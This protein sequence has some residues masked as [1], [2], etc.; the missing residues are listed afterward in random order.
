MKVKMLKQT[1]INKPLVIG[2]EVE[3]LSDLAVRLIK[4][5]I[6]EEMIPRND[7]GEPDYS[8]MSNKE[9][10]VLCKERGIVLDK[11]LYTSKSAEEK[12]E[13]L[14]ERLSEEWIGG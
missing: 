1:F 11:E 13:Y 9:L 5:G 10:F 7:A 12:K 14:I 3:L 2:E 8:S 4:R 6:A